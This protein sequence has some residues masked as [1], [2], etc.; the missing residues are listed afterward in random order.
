MRSATASMDARA[1]SPALAPPCEIGKMNRPLFPPLPDGREV[2]A[3]EGAKRTS[4][5]ASLSTTSSHVAYSTLFTGHQ[6]RLIV[7]VD[8]PCLTKP[9]A[10]GLCERPHQFPVQIRLLGPFSFP[11]LRRRLHSIKIVSRPPRSAVGT[12]ST[13]HRPPHSGTTSQLQR[14]L[15]LGRIVVPAHQGR[16]VPPNAD[17]PARARTD[18]RTARSRPVPTCS[19]AE[20][21]CETSYSSSSMM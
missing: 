10:E 13:C 6:A 16:A 21:S 9:R 12:A 14:R 1:L 19:P 18:G 5:R 4:V 2:F 3:A 11:L 15:H 8:L 7:D 20:F 17:L